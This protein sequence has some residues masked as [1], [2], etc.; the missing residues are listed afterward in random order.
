VNSR[1]AILGR[2]RAANA[3]A[4]PV[5][6]PRGYRQS[7]TYQPGDLRLL[8]LFTQRLTDYQATV[9]RCTPATL[10]ATLAEACRDWTVAV[11]P[12]ANHP[13]P[14]N[15]LEP[16]LHKAGA[17]VTGCAAACAETGT[18]VLDGGPAQGPRALT[19][20]PDRHI[21]VVTAAQVVHTIPELL[22]RL[23]PMRPLT[24][25]SGPSATSDIELQ[26]VEGVH[27]PRTLIAI[28]V[29]SP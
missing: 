19:L 27:G 6:V 16:D 20:I 4:A 9:Y 3:A 18:I 7:G 28:V 12:G 29:Q 8:D 17:A 15:A 2:I 1:E 23:N 24:F 21:C 25:I 26:R 13:V 10:A 5:S 14:D 11:A 22:A